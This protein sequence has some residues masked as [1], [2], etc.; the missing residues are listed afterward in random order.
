MIIAF[1][2]YSA[3]M[4]NFSA[5]SRQVSVSIGSPVAAIMRRAQPAL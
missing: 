5:F 2:R 1:L 3:V 4:M